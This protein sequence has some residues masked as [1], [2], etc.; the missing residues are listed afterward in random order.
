VGGA[1][2]LA[3]SG[4]EDGGPEKETGEREDGEEESMG[5]TD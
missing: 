1:V 2:G 4:E 3:A 5:E